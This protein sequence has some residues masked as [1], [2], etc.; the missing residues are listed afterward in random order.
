[1]GR[2][3]AC[4]AILVASASRRRPRDCQLVF[5]IELCPAGFTPAALQQ[6]PTQL[7]ERPAFRDD[8]PTV[9]PAQRNRGGV[10]VLYGL[11]RVGWA[12]TSGWEVSQ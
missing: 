10:D 11:S 12:K 1:M 3:R 9:G 4:R 6:A 5:C 8:D 7:V 2:R